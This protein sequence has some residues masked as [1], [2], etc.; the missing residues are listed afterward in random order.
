MG[1]SLGYEHVNE[2][3]LQLKQS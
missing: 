1:K 2:K 3:E